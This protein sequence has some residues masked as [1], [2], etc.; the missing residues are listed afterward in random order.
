[1]AVCES[2]S[3]LLRKQGI[4][5]ETEDIDSIIKNLTLDWLQDN[6]ISKV[7]YNYSS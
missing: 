5:F 7:N 6:L 4:S 2:I 1:M 3:F